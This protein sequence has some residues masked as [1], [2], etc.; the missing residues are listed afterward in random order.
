MKK[1]VIVLR[2]AESI[3]LIRVL[4]LTFAVLNKPQWF[5]QITNLVLVMDICF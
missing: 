1:T 3:D 5:C 4:V 2:H